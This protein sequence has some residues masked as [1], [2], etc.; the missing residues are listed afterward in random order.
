MAQTKFYPAS[1][2]SN[3]C[4]S[5]YSSGQSSSCK[6]K[7]GSSQNSTYCGSCN[8]SCNTSQAYCSIG[9][10]LISSHGD[11][12]SFSGFNVS[13]DD[14]I[15]KKWTHEK[16]N[17][18]QNKY[19]IAGSVGKTFSQGSPS[20]TQVDTNDII[21]ADL[22]NEFYTAA[23][24]FNAS[25]YISKVE[26]NNVIK[27]SHSTALENSFSHSKFNSSVC[28]ICN[29]GRQHNCGYNCN[30]NYNC[31]HNCDY[32]CS[33]NCSYNCNHNCNHDE[34]TTAS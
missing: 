15:F 1:S 14:I 25:S 22:Y 20:F 3:I 24:N 23:Q 17:Q 31:N 29:V 5:C 10:Q 13:K 30:C 27:E 32:N 21:T 2:V 33:Y 12:G 34:K 7:N 16:W 8:T 6:P 11:V 9:Y 28:D 19:K 26:K 18:L 4:T